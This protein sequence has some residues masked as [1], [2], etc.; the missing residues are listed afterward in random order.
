MR[1]TVKKFASLSL[2]IVGLSLGQAIPARA[3]TPFVN[4]VADGS[5]TDGGFFTSLALDRRGNPHVTYQERTNFDLL[6]ARKAAGGWTIEVVDGLGDTGRYTSLALDAQGNPR[7]AYHDETNFDLLYAR[8]SGGAWT[9]ERVDSANLTGF[10]A[11]LALDTQGNPHVGYYDATTTDL[12][13]A[14]KIGGIWTM[15]TVDGATGFVGF[16]PSLALDAQGNPN[17]TY[18]DAVN[19]NLKYARKADGIWKREIA[20]ASANDVG[21][22]S[23]LAIDAQGVVHV[24][25]SDAT[26]AN[27]LYARRSAGIWTRETIDGSG[28]G[29]EERT[30]LALDAQGNPNVAYSDVLVGG[31]LR[32]ARKSGSAWILEVA[33]AS[34]STVGR[35]CSLALDAQGNPRASYWDGTAGNLKY[36]DASVQLLS[37]T[38]GLTWAVGSLQEIAW[39]G[40][41][42]VSISISSDGGTTYQLLESGIT[43]SPYPV[44]VTHLPTRFARVRIERASPFS[45]AAT[46]SFF[47]IDATITLAKF[48]TT[49]EEA[50]ARLTWET[51][52][53][54]EAQ[55]RYRVERATDGIS[56]TSIAD[57]LEREEY[58]DPSPTASSHYRLI[59]VNGLG[60]EYVLGESAIAPRLSTDR[61][62]V[63]YPNPASGPIEILYRVPVGGPVEL[64]VYDVSGRR[65]RTLAPEG[66]STDLESA[67][68]DRLDSSGRVVAPGTYFFR[69]SGPNG[70]L[71]TQRVTI[72]R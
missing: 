21:A 69:L 30:S 8:K 1:A 71:V 51:E 12:M 42:P 61:D 50:G 40:V 36:A 67:T 57:G 34:P 41:G 58:V 9:I 48:K 5:A 45:S 37:P 20:D 3:V 53:G 39:T 31:D 23:S 24:S 26:A 64:A 4:E 47:K 35:Y 66:A 56:F 19:G 29:V 43:R 62:I 15:D 11:S 10:Y 25:Y 49:R 38:G 44:R 46:D 72:A 63:A 16:W 59:A 55:I 6:Y 18:H 32:Y 60:D 28:I 54:P 13:Y 70:Y 14:R 27:L 33:D 7:I 68:W 2:T 22:Y 17:V 52:P 65:I